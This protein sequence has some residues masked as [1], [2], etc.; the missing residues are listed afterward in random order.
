MIIRRTAKPLRPTRPLRGETPA[1]THANALRLAFLRTQPPRPI[2]IPRIPPLIDAK[3][4]AKLRAIAVRSFA[5]VVNLIKIC[6]RQGVIE[7]Q[8]AKDS[9]PKDLTQYKLIGLP[10]GETVAGL[11]TPT[12]KLKSTHKATAVARQQ[13]KPINL[14]DLP[15]A[16]PRAAEQSVEEGYKGATK[17]KFIGLPPG[18]EMELAPLQEQPGYTAPAALKTAAERVTLTKAAQ[19]SLPLPVKQ[20]I[21]RM[22]TALTAYSA[23]LQAHGIAKPIADAIER[24]GASANVQIAKTLGI[25]P[26]RPDLAK[27]RNRWVADNASL[28]KSIP[29]VAADRAQG[30]V[31]QMVE[32]GSRWETIAKQL[33]K[34]LEITKNRAQLI[35]RDQVSKYNA[36]LNQANQRAA[37]IQSYVWRGVKDNRERPEHLALEGQVFSW[38][39]P[40]YLGNP[41]EPIRCRCWAEPNTSRAISPPLS[42]QDLINRTAAQGPKQSM[43]D[44][45]P[46]EVHAEAARSV[47][48]AIKLAENRQQLLSR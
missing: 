17:Y 31:Q 30:I 48:A 23:D 44:A 41:G 47:K 38:D 34:E 33:E 29:T 20:G 14:P 6:R 16:P 11:P 43:P 27:L 22:R 4:D 9:D 12:P 7:R 25:Q 39:H 10:E 1:P 13:P 24:H 45:T 5:A 15:S 42:E 32:N 19:L 18:E 8:D 26:I 35:A 37:G 40:S 46:A 21:G 2:P 36:A 3:Y 28:I